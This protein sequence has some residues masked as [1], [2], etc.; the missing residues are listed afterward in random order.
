MSEVDILRGGQEH[1]LSDAELRRAHLEA[2]I[3][4]D[5]TIATP[6]CNTHSRVLY[7]NERG[8]RPGRNRA[9]PYGFPWLKSPLKEKIDQANEF[10]SFSID[11]LKAAAAAGKLGLSEHPEDLGTVHE[12]CPASIWQLK[13]MRDLEEVGYTSWAVHQSDFGAPYAKPTRFVDNANA[14]PHRHIHPGWPVL[15]ANDKYLGPLPR[16]RKGLDLKRSTDDPS[17]RTGPTSAYPPDLCKLLAERIGRDYMV[18]NRIPP[19]PLEGDARARLEEDVLR[20]RQ[21]GL[22]SGLE[23]GHLNHVCGLNSQEVGTMGHIEGATGTT[24][25]LQGGPGAIGTTGTT[26]DGG[27]M[28]SSSNRPLEEVIMSDRWDS[29]GGQ[30]QKGAGWTGRG[31]PIEVDKGSR[32]RDLRDGAGL[33]S[34]GRWPKEARQLPDV[35]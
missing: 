13:E 19:A 35:T 29:I 30:P 12:S 21:A 5:V 26:G 22:Y 20:K 24:R 3:I 28:A 33:C 8:P 7:A 4:P 18:R 6:P 27:E 10:V 31:K 11:L 32:R 15:D 23:S 1:D 2:Q 16:P 34:P 25:G 17:F 9:Y 14:D